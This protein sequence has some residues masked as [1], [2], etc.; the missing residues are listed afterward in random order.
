MSTD[1]KADQYFAAIRSML[2][3]GLLTQEQHDELQAKV[4]QWADRTIPSEAQAFGSDCLN[5]S[6]EF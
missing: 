5:G 2:R 1:V 6:C 3:D 4:N